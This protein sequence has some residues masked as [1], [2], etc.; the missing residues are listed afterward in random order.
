[1]YLEFKT[2]YTKTIVTCSPGTRSTHFHVIYIS[3]NGPSTIP[4]LPNSSPFAADETPNSRDSLHPWRWGHV[5]EGCDIDDKLVTLQK[6]LL[7]INATGFCSWRHVKTMQLNKGGRR[8]VC[9]GCIVRF[10]CCRGHWCDRRGSSH[11]DGNVG[12]SDRTIHLTLP[13]LRHW[14]GVCFIFEITPAR[15]VVFNVFNRWFWKNKVP[16]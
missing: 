7:K 16:F 12:R 11:K 8:A 4:H 1:M 9:Q 5:M 15:I 6:Y 13:F 10:P 3:A 14:I 2:Y